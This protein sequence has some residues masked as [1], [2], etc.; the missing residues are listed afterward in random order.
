MEVKNPDGSSSDVVAVRV[1]DVFVTFVSGSSAQTGSARV[2]AAA[3]VNSFFIVVILY[4]VGV[5]HDVRNI[6]LATGTRHAALV[7]TVQR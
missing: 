6:G 4:N 5:I 2:R 7:V 3:I 1:S